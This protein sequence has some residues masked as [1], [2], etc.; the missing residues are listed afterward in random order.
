MNLII[1]RTSRFDKLLEALRNA[2]KKGM[3]AAC[4]AEA[5]V[6]KLVFMTFHS[7]EL[8]AKR[9]K[10]GELRVR[11][12]QKFDLGSGYRL[13]CVKE[14]SHLFLLYI[15]SHDDCDRWLENNRGIQLEL[16]SDQDTI[17][18]ME[19]EACLLTMPPME[20]DIEAE[21]DE[22]EKRLMAKLDDKI[23]RQIFR[24]IC[25]E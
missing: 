15:G 5:I 12:C 9:T 8:V 14:D 7:P 22:Y 23:L 17:S 1:H 25:K 20:D 24:G 10:R 13:I 3:L 16:E 11:N 19:K 6:E 4:K 18:F 2:D 21:S